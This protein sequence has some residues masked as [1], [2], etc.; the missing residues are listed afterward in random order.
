MTEFARI[1]A[2]D[3]VRKSQL[4]R[5]TFNKFYLAFLSR[6]VPALWE[7]LTSLEIV[8]DVASPMPAD[9]PV[10][11]IDVKAAASL[12]SMSAGDFANRLDLAVRSWGSYRVTRLESI[13]NTALSVTHAATA[14]AEAE[15]AAIEQR[16]TYN[17]LK[18]FDKITG[19][20]KLVAV[21]V[22]VGGIVVLVVKY[23]PRGRGK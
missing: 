7:H 8:G 18:I 23:G 10:A 22:V 14:R 19:T 6:S 13:D 3:V 21:A 11:V 5:V 20:L 1:N 4:F 15:R 16:Q 17:P 2:T 12:P 9:G